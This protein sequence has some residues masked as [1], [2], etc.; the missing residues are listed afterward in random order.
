MRQSPL[1]AN[2]SIRIPYNLQDL[3]AER[4]HPTSYVVSGGV[5]SGF[6]VT[7]P[8]NSMITRETLDKIG[9][10]LH[11]LSGVGFSL[12][13]KSGAGFGLRWALARLVS[14][15]APKGATVV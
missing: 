7:K 5:T 6:A 4:V 14:N 15:A 2:H 12:L 13:L 3:P 8:S 1:R 11:I 9:F 10:V